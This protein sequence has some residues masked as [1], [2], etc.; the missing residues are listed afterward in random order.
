LESKNVIKI[1]TTTAENLD[2]ILVFSAH[3]PNAAAINKIAQI[4]QCCSGEMKAVSLK[5]NSL[6]EDYNEL[7]AI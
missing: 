2:P 5:M 6:C 1:V 7:S 4:A 3:R